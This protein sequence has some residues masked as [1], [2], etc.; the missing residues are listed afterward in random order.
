VLRPFLLV[1]VGGSGGKTLRVIREELRRRLQQAG[2]RDELPKAWQFVYVDVPTTPDGSESDLPSQLPSRDYTG[3]VAPGL[4]YRALDATLTGKA[5]DT[6]RDALGAWRPDPNK[7]NIPVSKGA[8]QFRAIGR[9][10][11]L[12]GLDKVQGALESARRSLTGAEVIGELQRLTSQLG[13][14]PSPHMADP[15]VIVVS[16]IAGGSGAGAVIDVCD[17]IRSLGD[18]W[19][20]ESLALLYAPDVFD[21]LPEEHRKGVRPNSLA[22]LGELLSGYWNNEGPSEETAELLALK[23]VQVGAANRVGPRYPF[24]VGNRNEH[25]S[26]GTQNDIYRAMG[27]SISAWVTS[28]QLQDR[29]TA[30]LQGNWSQSASA[31][32][33]N[34]PLH[35]QGTETPFSALGSSRVGLG[36]DRFRQYAGE[37]LAR[38]AV[39]RVLRRHLESRQDGDDRSDQAIA[40]EVAD[41]TFPRFLAHSGL[42]ERTDAHNDIL[43][44]LRP[45]TATSDTHALEG[46]I[47]AHVKKN[48]PAKG[49]SPA[50]VSGRILRAQRDRAPHY[51]QTRAEARAQRA[52]AWVVSI[53]GQLEAQVARQVAT[54]GGPVTVLL[55]QRLV[56]ELEAV[57]EELKG[58][59]NKYFRWADDV[60]QEVDKALDIRAERLIPDNPAIR[61]GTRAAA[62]ALHWKAEGELRE[63]AVDLIPDLV[64][65]VVRPLEQALRFAVNKLDQE[66][67]SAPPA[68]ER[69]I[70]DWPDGDVVPARLAE[71][72][73]E[74]LL[75]S[76]SEY[77]TILQDVI[78][79]TMGSQQPRTAFAQAVQWLLLG[80]H[81]DSEPTQQ[82]IQRDSN[83]VP[84]NHMLGT[85]APVSAS[86]RVAAGGQD[87]LRRADEWIMSPGT[88]M[89]RY[90][91]E[92]LADY[93]SPESVDPH[94]HARRLQR[95]EGQLIAALNASA[96]LVKINS[97]VLVQVHDEAEARS[98]ISFSELP[99]ADKSPAKDRLRKVLQAR[100]Q[101]TPEVEK[102]FTDGDQSFIDMFATLNRPYEPVVFDSLM[103][104]IA[105]EWGKRS[106]NSDLI[107]EFWRWRR[108]RPL[109]ES[110]PL[111]PSVREAMV[112]GWFTA[113]RLGHLRLGND[114][115]HIFVPSARGRGEWLQFPDPLLTGSM[116]APQ[117]YLP[118][119]LESILLAMVEV[120]TTAS[121]KPMQ[122]YHRL[123]DLGRSGSGGVERYEDLNAEL[124]TWI[125]DGDAATATDTWEQRKQTVVENFKRL[126]DSYVEFFTK[127]RP[128]AD[129]LDVPTA[130]DLRRDIMNALR[131][132]GRAV[133]AV[134]AATDL[135]N[136]N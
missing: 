6:V 65:N 25:V 47:Y 113:S 101:W 68:G 67:R 128:Y 87:L 85:G 8:G 60:V 97:Q 80:V 91:G 115:V 90:L 119:V 94:E 12:T 98:T 58:E 24:L 18:T 127:N 134:T 36:R 130:Y 132:L 81:D 126:G 102:A 29:I 107:Q 28:P 42:D 19:A 95:F 123:R 32:V 96:P 131:D 76:T 106:R 83:W 34:L 10:V 105:R 37:R 112:R 84:Q 55:L 88:A 17:A 75:E 64:A 103:Q 41:K 99:F 118:V 63:L 108:A 57:T 86:F 14:E 70:S 40:Q 39:D 49:E 89:G 23:G 114:Q 109:P 33:D 71:A 1:G 116:I 11:T 74:F 78:G 125:L 133:Q 35:L 53:Q 13:G 100:G 44:A 4:T 46:Q 51:H 48:I 50:D 121:L 31:L 27:R 129:P 69:G 111:S 104:P 73:N 77:W 9:M 82:L 54:D 20:S 56:T 92:N 43:D 136:W 5:D 124:R 52:E 59:A 15:T 21:Y 62:E 38:A 3:M 93:L 117:Q 110:L 135:E 7:V 79:R 120:N 45:D 30:Y 61:T 22:T 66:E 2:W 26:Y 72:P 122:P 16:S